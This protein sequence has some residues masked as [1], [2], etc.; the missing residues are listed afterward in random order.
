MKLLLFGKT[1]QVA[2]RL[3]NALL[4][5]GEVICLGREDADFNDFDQLRS[6]IRLHKPGIIINAVAYTAVDEAESKKELCFLINTEAVKV[7][8][9]EA[10][11]LNAWLIHYSSDY[12]FDGKATEPYSEDKVPNPLSIYGKSKADADQYIVEN[13]SKHTILRTS[14]VFDSYGKNFPKTILKLAKKNN[15]LKIVSDQISVPTSACLIANVTAFILYKMLSSSILPNG[16]YNIA[17]SEETSWYDFAKYLV[18]VAYDR[19][20]ELRCTPEDVLPISS[21]E[22]VLPAKRPTFS[23]LDTSK[24]CKEFNLV[25]PS[26]KLY[27]PSLLEDLKS[28]G[29]L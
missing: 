9:D 1:G 16:I 10:E 13:C 26:W 27:V 18:K 2:R 7:I 12:V 23:K 21:A 3:Y 17:S 14:A 22:Y 24:L 6:S 20:F 15:V 8:A 28:A 11:K 25:M 19:G 5:I 4:P 29:E